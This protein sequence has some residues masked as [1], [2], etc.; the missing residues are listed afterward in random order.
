MT[1]ESLTS[2]DEM[3]DAAKNLF[4]L[5]NKLY[6]S[7]RM[8]LDLNKKNKKIEV[9]TLHCYSSACTTAAKPGRPV[10]V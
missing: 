7:F 3:H 5:S 10:H 9:N 2:A 1:R 8:H 6:S 4:L